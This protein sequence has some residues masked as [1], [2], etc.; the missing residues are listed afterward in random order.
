MNDNNEGACGEAFMCLVKW[1]GDDSSAAPEEI[2]AAF[3]VLGMHEADIEYL[4]R[5]YPFNKPSI[6]PISHFIKF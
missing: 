3:D 4:C 5:K 1:L 6:V 2:I